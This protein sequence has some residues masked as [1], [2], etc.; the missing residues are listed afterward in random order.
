MS[1]SSMFR[2]DAFSGLASEPSLPQPTQPPRSER[3]C[4]GDMFEPLRH[5]HS[6]PACRDMPIG[7]DCQQ[8][9]DEG[10]EQDKSALGLQNDR[11]YCIEG[12]NGSPVFIPSFLSC[13][14]KAQPSTQPSQ[15][16]FV[17]PSNQT[18]I[19]YIGRNCHTSNSSQSGEVTRHA[20]N[21]TDCQA[22]CLAYNTNPSEP[23]KMGTCASAVFLPNNTHPNGINCYLKGFRGDETLKR[24]IACTHSP[25][26]QTF[27]Q[28]SYVLPE[29]NHMVFVLQS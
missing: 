28:D 4:S 3:R 24:S 18:W 2:S 15:S 23:L 16:A 10:F 5:R 7:S 22:Q 1:T 17:A 12:L 14:K 11:A 8:F 29:Y 27:Y 6:S 20:A 13:V 26:D 21:A 25:K 19:P 9:C